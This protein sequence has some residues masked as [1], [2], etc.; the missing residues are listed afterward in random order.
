MV[1][2]A[3]KASPPLTS[4]TCLQPSVLQRLALI[5]HSLTVQWW[6]CPTHFRDRER[7]WEQLKV[8]ASVIPSA[9]FLQHGNQ[10]GVMPFLLKSKTP[11]EWDL[12]LRTKS[13]NSRLISPS[14]LCVGFLFVNLFV[15]LGFG[16]FWFLFGVFFWGGFGFCWL[17]NIFWL[18][19]LQSGEL[20]IKLFYSCKMRRN[21]RNQGHMVNSKLK[22]YFLVK[23]LMFTFSFSHVL[24]AFLIHFTC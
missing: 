3:V 22:H 18:E 7:V 20:R 21:R 4:I 6:L 12:S 16:W 15:R 10:V 19:T 24:S 13:W 23:I 2:L 17:S 1:P 5:L 11:F 8:S 14:V 9:K